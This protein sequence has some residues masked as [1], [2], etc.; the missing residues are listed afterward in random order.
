MSPPPAPSP[1]AGLRVVVTRPP[2][3]ARGLADALRDLG[4]DVALLPLLEVVEG[5][6]LAPLDRA[7]RDLDR[8]GWIAFTSAN[9]VPPVVARRPPPWPAGLRV[10][11]VSAATAA[12]LREAGV[13][14]E[15][16][17][18]RGAGAMLAEG[19]RAATPRT[20]RRALIP[21]AADALPDLAR[22][23]RAAGFEVDT[24]VAYDKRMAPT[25][26]RRARGLFPAGA[27]LGWV[28]FTSP[29]IARTFADLVDGLGAGG[30]AGRR[31]TLRAASI[32]PT[33]SGELRRLGVEPAAEADLPSDAALA[34][35]VASSVT[36]AARP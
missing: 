29:R 13:E 8:Y 3:Q 32:G 19:I 21:Q 9:A 33:T 22:D 7:L 24:V 27:P 15:V 25:A 31:P 6:D 16:F 4:A 26:A 12:A 23:L 17:A 34:A 1:L 35:A 28:T 20:R 18:S 30:W 11:A 10:V 5:D 2:H 14:P 36:G